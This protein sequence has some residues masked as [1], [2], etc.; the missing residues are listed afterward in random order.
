MARLSGLAAY[1][2]QQRARAVGA[3]LVGDGPPAAMPV[4]TEFVIFGDS[5][6]QRASASTFYIASTGANDSVSSSGAIGWAKTLLK[7]RIRFRP[8]LNLGIAGTTTGPE[9]GANSMIARLPDALSLASKGRAIAFLGGTNNLNSRLSVER[10]TSDYTSILDALRGGYGWVFVQ[11]VAPR[12]NWP[13]DFTSQ[14]IADARAKIIAFNDFL[15]IYC[16]R[17]SS[18]CIYVDFFQD[19]IDSATGGPKAGYTDEGTHQTGLGAYYWGKRLRDAIN[20]VLVSG[21][22]IWSLHTGSSDQ[23]DDAALPFGNKVTATIAALN[24]G[25]AALSTN[26]MSGVKA[27]GFDVS[28]SGGSSATNTGTGVGSVVTVDGINRQVIDWTSRSGGQENLLATFRLNLSAGKYAV[29]ERIVAAIA[30]KATGLLNVAN[31][32]LSLSDYPGT[33]GTT[34][35]AAGQLPFSSVNLGAT[36]DQEGVIMTAPHIVQATTGTGA[37]F[38]AFNAVL[39]LLGNLSGGSSGHLE[40]WLPT[41]RR[42]NLALV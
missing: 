29:G 42:A 2:A 34:Q 23:F 41:V 36:E 33:S 24:G 25:T 7:Q 5:M 28:F 9:G 27:T 26:G 31:L 17:H 10:T 37:P 13:S 22:S 38:I 32:Q 15:R 40:L 11:S 18:Q 8:E 20:K 16:A 6:T 39:S 21:P 35:T 3:G 1:R 19:W 4:G 12:A 14:D 30:Y